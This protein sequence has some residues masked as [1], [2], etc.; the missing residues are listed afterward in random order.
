LAKRLLW[1]VPAGFVG[2]LFLWPLVNILAKGFA[3]EWAHDLFDARTLQLIWF[4]GWQAIVSTLLCLVLGIPGAYVLYRKRFRGQRVIRA[5]ITIP[6]MLPTIVVATAFSVF[7]NGNTNPIVL[8]II[9]HV[10]INYSLTVRT[11]GSQWVEL[12]RTTEEAGALSGAGRMRILWSIT[13]PQLKA[14][15]V[16]S[17]A[18]TF[19]YCAAS[20]GIILV[21]GGGGVHTL[22]TEIA[23]SAIG[24]LDL[25]RTAALA[26]IQTGLS[27]LAFTISQRAGRA[28]FGVGSVHYVESR[29]WL[30][31]RDL[32]AVLLTAAIVVG[33]LLVPMWDIFAR[34]FA[35]PSNFARLDSRGTRDLLN[36]SVLQAI[37]NSVRNLTISMLIAMS[38]GT[39]IAWLLARTRLRGIRVLVELL[40]VMPLGISTVVLG[41]GYLITFTNSTIPLRESWMVV[42][43]IQSVMAVPLVTRI[44]YPA[45][46]AIGDQQLET[47]ALDGAGAWKIWWEIEAPQIRSA[48]ST[49]AAFAGLVSIGEFGAASLLA[50]GDQATL[51]TVLYTLV[52]RPGGHNYGMAMAVSVLLILFTFLIVLVVSYESPRQLL[53]KRSVRA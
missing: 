26:L 12:D 22:E 32:P 4:T 35:D 27:V 20:Y 13:L 31:K 47:A 7:Q 48:I 30:D 19:M 44:I 9:A 5:L 2:L 28:D 21:L 41:F 33:L 42:P 52:S 53:R 34:A 29:D 36:I 51:P 15:I 50:F 45:L 39:L 37:G 40:M 23:N 24:L 14:S 16:S 10:F 18:T 49:A 43:L 1:L 38:V 6:F 3:Q 46:L 25:P 11:I 8:I 17:A